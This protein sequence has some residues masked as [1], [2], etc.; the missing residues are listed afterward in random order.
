MTARVLA[1]AR[2]ALRGLSKR[3]GLTLLVVVT[4]AVGLAANAA[5]FATV[6]ALLLRPLPFPNLPRLVRLWESAPGADAYAQ[7]TVG[8]ANVRGWEAQSA[9]VLEDL[10]ALE[11]WDANV[12]GRD[13]AERVQGY[14]VSPRFFETL[15]VAPQAGRG[16]LAGEGRPGNDRRVVIGHDLWQRA[17]GADRGLVGR[18]VVVDGEAHVVV[19]IAPRGFHFPYGAELWAPLALPATGRPRDR[20]ELA[21]IARLAPGRSLDD[22]VKTMTLVGQRLQRDHPDTNAQRGVVVEG[23]QRGYEDPASRPLLT[24]WQLA[25]AVV[26]LIACVNVANLLLARGAERQRELALRVALG[27]GRG[28]ILLQLP[29]EGLTTTALAVALSVPLT[30]WAARQLR[31]H[32][33]AEIAR[34][35]IGWDTIG[36]DAPTFA[37]A[38]ALGVLATLA[39]TLVPALRASRAGL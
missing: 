17:F 37:F 9:G 1:D 5:I 39:F 4:L 24:T 12:R 19:G 21:V 28:Q 7:D 31:E 34:F 13:V 18:T 14:H 2:F 32:M 25:A 27:A 16:F 10:V 35:V 38:A 8:P 33:P 29:V 23:L 3:P 30:V 6:N 22:A 15:G 26:M 36:F 20:H 11:W